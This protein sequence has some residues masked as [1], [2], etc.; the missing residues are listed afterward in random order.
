MH[1]GEK[2]GRKVRQSL[3]ARCARLDQELAAMRPNIG[4]H[5]EPPESLPAPFCDERLPGLLLDALAP[6]QA[7]MASATTG[8]PYTAVRAAMDVDNRRRDEFSRA[9]QVAAARSDWFAEHRDGIEVI[10]G[11]MAISAARVDMLLQFADAE[12]AG[13]G[14]EPEPCSTRDAVVIGLIV[15]TPVLLAAGFVLYKLLKKG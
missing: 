15:L 2:R 9:V 11:I 5:G 7:A 14:L 12:R 10:V 6:V 13:V 1:K 4:A 8:A 3:N